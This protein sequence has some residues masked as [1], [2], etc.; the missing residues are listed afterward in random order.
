M[1][2][3]IHAVSCSLCRDLGQAAD[4]SYSVA[5]PLAAKVL[6]EWQAEQEAP[7]GAPA[8][9]GPS[10]R[11]QARPLQALGAL[12]RV[13]ALLKSASACSRSVLHS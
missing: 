2:L 13:D 9:P 4:I 6:A 1:H 11:T 5:A 8:K 3:D 10:D 12:G 7:G